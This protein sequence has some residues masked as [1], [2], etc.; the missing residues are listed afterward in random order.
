M[1]INLRLPEVLHL[2][3]LV[4]I[5]PDRRLSR[6]EAKAGA[7][8]RRISLTT[9]AR[10]LLAQDQTPEAQEYD[11]GEGTSAQARANSSP[12]STDEEDNYLSRLRRP[13][14]VHDNL[15]SSDS[16]SVPDPYDGHTPSEQ[17]LAPCQC[18]EPDDPAAPCNEIPPRARPAPP[19]P[20]A[21]PV[22]PAPSINNPSSR[23][24]AAEPGPGSNDNLIPPS[25]AVS[26]HPRR[27]T[28][29]DLRRRTARPNYGPSLSA[30]LKSH[31][32]I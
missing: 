23:P 17:N 15:Q 31:L 30:I 32:N 22:P 9:I 19:A 27:V 18:D 4:H 10:S 2:Q 20:P 21:P 1:A 7:G 12:I 14:N 16:D 25:Q 24:V 6:G 8:G 11:P 26:P 5:H 13:R 3:I 28:S 29:S